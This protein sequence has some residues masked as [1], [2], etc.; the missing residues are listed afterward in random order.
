MD[1]VLRKHTSHCSSEVKE[2]LFEISISQN[3]VQEEVV[4]FIP[5][6]LHLRIWN[7]QIG[8]ESQLFAYK[9]KDSFMKKLLKESIDGEEV[10]F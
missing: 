4:E 8:R 2:V 1:T 5:Y 6:Y 3:G 9:G 7:C 10:W